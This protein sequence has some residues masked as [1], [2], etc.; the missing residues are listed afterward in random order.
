[1]PG[2]PFVVREAAAR[3]RPGLHITLQRHEQVIRGIVRSFVGDN[4]TMVP[5]SSS[6]IR[7]LRRGTTFTAHMLTGEGTL[8]ATLTLLSVN[9]DFTTLQ[10]KGLPALLQR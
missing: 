7:A 2:A 8:E 9:D 3:P 5:D 6:L 10:L 4:L 1:M